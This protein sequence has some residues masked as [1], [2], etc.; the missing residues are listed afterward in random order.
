LQVNNLQVYNVKSMYNILNEGVLGKDE[1]KTI[2][3]IKAFIL[4]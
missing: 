2:W 4:P 1:Y 3:K